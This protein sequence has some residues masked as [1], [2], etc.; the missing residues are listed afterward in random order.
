MQQ[1]HSTPRR[2]LYLTS[3][4]YKTF[5]R[6]LELLKLSLRK[7][8][9]KHI[10]IFPGFVSLEPAHQHLAL[11]HPPQPHF[12]VQ[13]LLASA[14]T[15]WTRKEPSGSFHQGPD[16]WGWT[17]HLG[18]SAWTIVTSLQALP[19]H[20]R[21]QAQAHQALVHPGRVPH[22]AHQSCNLRHLPMFPTFHL[23]R[24]PPHLP[25][26]QVLRVHQAHQ[27][28]NFCHPPM[29]PS[30]HLHHHLPQALVHPGLVPR[31]VPP[32]SNMPAPPTL[33][34]APPILPHVWT[35]TN[36]FPSRSP[37]TRAR[38]QAQGSRSGAHQAALE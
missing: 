10:S 26:H 11:K 1:Y 7:D 25:L 19:V 32:R 4:F 23:H 8:W 31:Q 15:T 27:S 2:T 29:C 37:P 3:G 35:T 18:T 5:S 12:K 16:S 22:Q 17:G 28:C 6:K 38:V 34:P 21:A 33:P 9:M 36:L 30:F 13:L 20:H 24:R 14:T